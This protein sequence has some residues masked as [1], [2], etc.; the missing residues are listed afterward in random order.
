M[1]IARDDGGKVLLML[2]I[3]M[4]IVPLLIVAFEGKSP[5]HPVPNGPR[6]PALGVFLQHRLSEWQNRSPMRIALT[7]FVYTDAY[8]AVLESSKRLGK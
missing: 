2:I 4:M 8:I 3:P 1:R 5:P 6:R 7:W